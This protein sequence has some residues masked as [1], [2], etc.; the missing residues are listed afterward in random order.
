MVRKGP[1]PSDRFEIW[2]LADELAS[3]AER[4]VCDAFTN[5]VNGVGKRPTQL[6]LDVSHALRISAKRMLIAATE[7]IRPPLAACVST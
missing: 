2:Q 3:A 4:I 5:S 6:Q 1:S 7:D